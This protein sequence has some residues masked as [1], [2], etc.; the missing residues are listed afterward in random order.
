MAR[1]TAMRS[2]S[3]NRGLIADG[4]EYKGTGCQYIMNQE[5]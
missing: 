4:I 1:T 2:I 5:E 3:L